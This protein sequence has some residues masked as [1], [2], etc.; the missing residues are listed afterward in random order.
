MLPENLVVPGGKELLTEPTTPGASQGCRSSRESSW[1]PKLDHLCIK[2][3]TVISGYNPKQNINIH[4]SILIQICDLINQKVVEKR[5]ISTNDLWRH[6]VL[7]EV[8][9]DSPLLHVGCAVTS[10]QTGQAGRGKRGQ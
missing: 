9:H 5:Q 6:C 2:T 1:W 3:N 10:F 4:E 7:K 8:S